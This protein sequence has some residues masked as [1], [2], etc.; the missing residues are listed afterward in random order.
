MDLDYFL[1]CRTLF[2]W[3]GHSCTMYG[4]YFAET[5]V[6]G[7]PVCFWSIWLCWPL[8]LLCLMGLQG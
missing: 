6:F 3:V 4:G 7:A 2:C 1:C 5:K 8:G